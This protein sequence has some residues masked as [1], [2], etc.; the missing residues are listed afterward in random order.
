M[1]P[2]TPRSPT[3]FRERIALDVGDARASPPP[4]IRGGGLPGSTQVLL[5]RWSCDSHLRTSDNSSRDEVDDKDRGEQKQTR[6]CER[7]LSEM[8][9]GGKEICDQRW[10]LSSPR[11]ENVQVDKVGLRQDEEHRNGL[12]QSS[13]QAKKHAAEDPVS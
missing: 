1:P 3:L 13:S 9:Q 8:R 7:T 12:S 2:G 11:S 10:D 6:Q 5:G 4:A